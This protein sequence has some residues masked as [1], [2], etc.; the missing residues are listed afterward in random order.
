[1]SESR[2]PENRA[3]PP[4]G[5][6]GVKGAEVSWLSGSV[7]SGDPAAEGT[8]LWSHILRPLAEDWVQSGAK[9]YGKGFRARDWSVGVYWDGQGD[10]KG[11]AYVEVRQSACSRLPSGDLSDLLSAIRSRRLDLARDDPYQRVRPR[12]LFH[13]AREARSRTHKSRWRLDMTNF[14]AETTLY[15]GA[16]TSDGYLRV[17]DKRLSESTWGVR[18]ELEIKGDRALDAASFLV[19]G[20]PVDRLYASE[21]VRV[22]SWPTVPAWTALATSWGLPEAV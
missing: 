16:R 9:H 13:G 15:V 3:L 20:W 17:Y 22:V 18:H 8:R 19:M 14:G 2:P 4:V 21:Y 11:T 7:R 5:N 1:M 10:A 6:T 12:D